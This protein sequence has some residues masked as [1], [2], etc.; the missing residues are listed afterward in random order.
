MT[1]RPIEPSLGSAIPSMSNLRACVSAPARKRA[2]GCLPEARHPA[3]AHAHARRRV[4]APGAP[5]CPARG[6]ARHLRGGPV[7]GRRPSRPVPAARTPAAPRTASPQSLPDLSSTGRSSSTH[8]R[9]PSC[10]RSCGPHRV[11]QGAQG[12]GSGR[13][14]TEHSCTH[15]LRQS[16]G[17]V[18]AAPE[19]ARSA[20]PL[21]QPARGAALSSH[22]AALRAAC[23]RS[24]S[25]CRVRGEKRKRGM[26]TCDEALR[27]AK[28]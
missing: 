5:G 7:A 21:A 13:L 23:S 1:M 3:C 6:A 14:R 11:C 9:L 16:R 22:P 25:S 2:A 10:T 26:E 15:T 18:P 27:V 24:W 19:S 8:S 12:G 28:F 20:P 17:A 4:K